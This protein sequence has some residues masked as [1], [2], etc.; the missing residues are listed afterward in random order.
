MLYWKTFL[1]MC[2]AMFIITL[3]GFALIVLGVC[4]V[5]RMN[6]GLWLLFGFW[7]CACIMS[8]L[9]CLWMLQAEL[10]ERR[11]DHEH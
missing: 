4:G 11:P 5:V 6:A 7:Q 1:A 3:A 2:I 8:S 10:K 9:I